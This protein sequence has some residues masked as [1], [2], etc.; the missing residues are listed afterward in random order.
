MLVTLIGFQVPKV[1]FKCKFS[2][3]LTLHS[4]EAILA[5]GRVHG[6]KLVFTRDLE[7]LP[8]G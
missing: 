2:S 7:C 4:G 8:G 3:E 6:M 5:G 1:I